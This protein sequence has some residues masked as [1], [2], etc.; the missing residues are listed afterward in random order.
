MGSPP[1]RVR[2]VFPREPTPPPP[3][4]PG[5]HSNCERGREVR[6][7]ARVDCGGLAPTG[8]RWRRRWLSAAAPTA[9]IPA[10]RRDRWTC[11]C[12]RCF[13]LPVSSASTRREAETGAKQAPY[14]H[15]PS[16]PVTSARFCDADRRILFIYFFR[17]G[18]SDSDPFPRKKRGV[19][20]ARRRP[21]APRSERL[22]SAAARRRGPA[23]ACVGEGGSTMRRVSRRRGLSEI[24][25]TCPSNTAECRQSARTR[26]R[27]PGPKTNKNLDVV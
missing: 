23:S 10:A 25:A 27:E 2:A 22:L 4:D 19:E 8:A 20:A 26:H 16:P 21:S 14:A 12:S 3:R 17:G 6:A 9:D 1:Q 11:L 24:R 5:T 18:G 15:D 7:A 13:P